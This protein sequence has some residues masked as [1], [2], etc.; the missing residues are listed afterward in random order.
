MISD[1]SYRA[2]VPVG[3]ALAEL[4]RHAGTQFD[5]QIVDLFH[6]LVGELV[7]DSRERAA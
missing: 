5:P 1:R 2:A 4:R 7:L 6:T 3:D